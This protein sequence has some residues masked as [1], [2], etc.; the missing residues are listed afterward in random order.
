[1]RKTRQ[2]D[3]PSKKPGKQAQELLTK[4]EFAAVWPQ[5]EARLGAT[6]G[7]FQHILVRDW[8]KEVAQAR[9]SLEK[10]LPTLTDFQKLAQEKLVTGQERISRQHLDELA[11]RW[12]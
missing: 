7:R 8:P 1:M 11:E 6:I 2:K 3:R 5:Y 4:D 12:T 9:A 10:L